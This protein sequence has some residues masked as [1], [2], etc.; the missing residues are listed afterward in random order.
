MSHFAQAFPYAARVHIEARR[1]FTDGFKA[2]QK[3]MIEAANVPNVAG[4]AVGKYFNLGA[5][6][7]HKRFAHAVAGIG[8]CV[9]SRFESVAQAARGIRCAGYDVRG[10]VVSRCQ[11]HVVNVC[12]VHLHTS[13]RVLF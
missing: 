3:I 9:Q 13:K 11:C 5:R 1:D 2:F 6:H 7:V 10:F 12:R 8:V 4:G